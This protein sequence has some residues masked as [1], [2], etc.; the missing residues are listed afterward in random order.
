M[1]F[2]TVSELLKG[3]AE[4]RDPFRDHAGEGA[5]VFLAHRETGAVVF[6]FETVGPLANEKVERHAAPEH[7]PT[8]SAQF[9]D[10]DRERSAD[11]GLD[12][13][14]QFGPEREF[15]LDGVYTGVPVR[16]GCDVGESSPDLLGSGLD[17]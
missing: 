7:H 13:D 1:F 6:R 11:V 5:G 4:V 10:R 2:E 12:T 14:C 15:S 9:L 3:R 17:Q 8:R 16:P